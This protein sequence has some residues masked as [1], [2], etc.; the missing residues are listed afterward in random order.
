MQFSTTGLLVHT[1]YTYIYIFYKLCWW[2]S[3]FWLHFELIVKQKERYFKGQLSTEEIY[4]EGKKL[5]VALVNLWKWKDCPSLKKSWITESGSICDGSH[6]C[7][8]LWVSLMSVYITEKEESI[9]NIVMFYFFPPDYQICQSM[10][11]LVCK[12]VIGK[13][14]HI[15][16][17]FHH[18]RW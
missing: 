5:T 15:N 9:L 17:A 2:P 3:S 14:W 6:L 8:H 10:Y 7:E 4:R 16:Y 11:W 1:L 13:Q 18:Y 12:G